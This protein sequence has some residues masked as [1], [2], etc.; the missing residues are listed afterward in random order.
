DDD[1]TL[2]PPAYSQSALPEHVALLKAMMNDLI[3]LLARCGVN[4][5]GAAIYEYPVRR[6][7]SSYPASQ[8]GVPRVEVRLALAD[9]L[10]FVER[11]GFRYCVDKALRASAAAVYWRTIENIHQQ[12]L[13]MS[14]RL[15]E[16]HVAQPA[17]S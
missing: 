17:L 16:L 15:E 7:A 5:E 9:G 1:A 8:D 12:R 2:E 10:S 14:D 6:T 11:V 13:W 4:T 3:C